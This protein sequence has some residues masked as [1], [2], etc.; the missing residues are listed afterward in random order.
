[1]T[2]PCRRALVTGGGSGIG[3]SIAWALVDAGYEVVV[4][5]R[6]AEKLRRTGLPHL[7]VD[8]TDDASVDAAAKAAG[9]IDVFIANAGAAPTSATLKTSREVWD[10]T[11]GVNLTG[12]FICAKA[13]APAMIQR[14]WGRFI[15]VASTAAYRAYP[16]AGAYVAAKHGLVGWI[17]ALALEHAATGVTFNSVCPGFTDT[18]LIAEAIN[19]LAMKGGGDSEAAKQSLAACNPMGRLVRPEEV[20]AA[21]LFLASDA[22][23]AVNGHSIVVD[24]G[25]LIA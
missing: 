8:V 1:M 14:R 21:V 18:P 15:A 19:R 23:S 7:V 5:G 11:I 9:E 20:A 22:A 13:F 10:Q 12:A 24:G 17:K 4:A 16:Y 25:E 6:D 2:S 3:H